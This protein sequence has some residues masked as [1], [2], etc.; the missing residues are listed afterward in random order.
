MKEV[1]SVQEGV[2]KQQGWPIIWDEVKEV[3][4]VQEGVSME[5]GW[6]IIWV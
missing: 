3:M 6:P 4:S 1:M 5:Q 2:S